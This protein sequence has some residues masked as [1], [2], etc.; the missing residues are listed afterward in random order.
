M[1]LCAYDQ[2]R[3]VG[4]RYETDDALCL[5]TSSFTEK[6][7][8]FSFSFCNSDSRLCEGPAGNHDLKTSLPDGRGGLNLLNI[9]ATK[10]SQFLFQLRDLLVC[11]GGH[12]VVVPSPTHGLAMAYGGGMWDDKASS[13]HGASNLRK[14]IG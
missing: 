13:P 4:G 1:C 9:Y 8:C 7:M 5:L 12:G 6:S 3:R 2:E 10:I 14:P 11:L